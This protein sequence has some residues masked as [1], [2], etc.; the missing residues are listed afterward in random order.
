MRT[1]GTFGW[2]VTFAVILVAAS[3]AVYGLT[4]EEAIGAAVRFLWNGL[5]LTVN[6]LMRLLASLLALVAKGVGWRRLS[7]LASSV[8]QIGLGYAG[9]LV[10]GDQ[11]VR[12]ARGWRE[13]LR[14]V[15]HI[16]RARWIALPLYGKLAVVG[17]LI[18][19]QL[20]VHSLLIVFP[21][22][23]LV[24]VVRRLWVQAADI[25]FG[26]WYW[27]TF[28]RW[29]FR[30]VTALETMPGP[31]HLL[32]ATRLARLRYL[33]AW[34]LWRYDPKYR[35]AIR[36]HRRVDLVEP[37]RLWRSGALDVY[38]GRPLLS[39]RRRT[40]SIE[41]TPVATPEPLGG[42]ALRAAPDPRSV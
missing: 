15:I 39:G 1:G 26:A 9:S 33:C 40:E 7:R 27:R 38:I 22:A 6:V 11:G 30:I 36:D 32:G 14:A 12:R 20:Y 37:L 25:A 19:T 29:H 35:D 4:G 16:M 34:R 17:F 8:G 23:F 24:P 5:A 41:P 2:Y 18:V 13:K 31:R 42:G 3:L 28:G 10:V 21:I